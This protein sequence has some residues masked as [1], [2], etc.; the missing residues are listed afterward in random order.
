MA[1][2]VD[3]D[4]GRVSLKI[5]PQQIHG[6][7][8]SVGGF[9]YAQ[10]YRV[11]GKTMEELQRTDGRKTPI[12][13]A[14]QVD[15]DGMT[16][17]RKLYEF[18]ELRKSDFARWCRTNITENEFAIENEDYVRL[19]IDAETPTGGKL[20]REDYKLTASFAKKLSMKGY[21][22]RAEQARNY[23]IGCE[24]AL[25]RLSKQKRKTEMERERGIAVRNAFT[26]A[27]KASNE[28]ERMHGHA[29]SVYTDVIYKVVF[30]KNAK[31]LREYYGIS[32][33]DKLRDCFTA[34]ELEKVKSIEMIVSG[35]MNFGWGYD[36][37][38]DFIM[39]PTKQLIVA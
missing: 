7:S 10:N 20:K 4:A 38:K 11:G 28:N 13:I 9:F 29:Y 6:N 16:T 3:E 36:D 37:I 2:P 18:L 5:F 8:V 21:G 24:Q 19:F 1:V 12:E 14:L 22:E 35:L 39:N 17:A 27:L 23:F 31:Q 34:E 15:D 33:T 30:G 26:D 32:K 25:V